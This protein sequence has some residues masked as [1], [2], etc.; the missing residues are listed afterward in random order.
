MTMLRSGDKDFL[1]GYLFAF[2]ELP[3]GA[4]QAACEEAIAEC[5]K[6]KGREP[7]DV[8]LAWCYANRVKP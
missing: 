2:D 1:D 7:Y 3:D 4:W 6:F 5:D 8:W